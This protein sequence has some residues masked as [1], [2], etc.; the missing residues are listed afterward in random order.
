MKEGLKPPCSLEIPP[1]PSLWKRG[2]YLERKRTWTDTWK[3]FSRRWRGMRLF[4]LAIVSKS[5]TD[6]LTWDRFHLRAKKKKFS[7]TVRNAKMILTRALS[8]RCSRQGRDGPAGKC[9][10][11]WRRLFICLG[12]L[13]CF[14]LGFQRFFVLEWKTCTV[15]K[16]LGEWV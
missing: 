2:C 7:G 16:F 5:K 4:L 1:P 13:S 6:E 8:S 12:D 14:H 9:V 15:V 3:L 10:E 11:L